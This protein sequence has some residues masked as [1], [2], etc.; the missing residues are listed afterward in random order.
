M[1][2][3]SVLIVTVLLAL[4]S[5]PAFAQ[6]SDDDRI[7]DEV[8]QRLSTNRDIKGGAIEVEVKDGVVTLRG[9]VMAQREKVKAEQ[10]A[11]KVK[12]VKKVINE[13]EIDVEHGG[14]KS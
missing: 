3:I 4:A 14:R 7:Y 5:R 9:K 2:C 8:R 10:V 11:K 1:R 6:A 12:K 13:L